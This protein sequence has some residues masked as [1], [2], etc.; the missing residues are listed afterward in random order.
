MEKNIT[1]QNAETGTTTLGNVV[2]E[3][4]SL[5]V[6]MEQAIIKVVNENGGFVRTTPNCEPIY[7]YVYNDE[8]ERI[9]EYRIL[10][11]TTLKDNNRLSILFGDDY[12]MYMLDSITKDKLLERK[13]WYLALDAWGDVL[14]NATL[15][16]ICENLEE[17]I[18]YMLAVEDMDE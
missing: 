10:A 9:E 16:S 6:K 4:Y 3:A 5:N 18:D 11:L 14:I 12:D 2:E 1:N 13:E 7:G 15:L 17:H 8:S